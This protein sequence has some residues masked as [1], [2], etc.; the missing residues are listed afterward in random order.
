MDLGIAS[1]GNLKEKMHYQYKN[2][3]L[4][5]SIRVQLRYDKATNY[6]HT[7]VGYVVDTLSDHSL[8]FEGTWSNGRGGMGQTW[9]K[10]SFFIPNTPIQV[11][12][13]T[14]LLTE[15]NGSMKGS[16]NQTE[17]YQVSSSSTYYG[18]IKVAEDNVC[19]P[20][21]KNRDAKLELEG[22]IEVSYGIRADVGIPF[23]FD[24]F[25]EGSLG[26]R[27]KGSF[28]MLGGNDEMGSIHDCERCLDGDIELFIKE[29]V[30][31]D[32]R[33][34]STIT[35]HDLVYRWNIA[36]KALK[37]GDFYASYREE[38]DGGVE[39]GFG[40]CPHLRY[41]V[42]VYVK[43]PDGKAAANA[44][45]SAIYPDQRMDAATAN[46]EGVAELYLP[47]GDNILKGKTTG[48]SGSIHVAVDGKPTETVLPLE[49][50]KTILF[51]I[52]EAFYSHADDLIEGLKER[53]PEA[54][55]VYYA[56]LLNPID[57]NEE[58]IVEYGLSKGDIFVD[59]SKARFVSSASFY[60]DDCSGCKEDSGAIH[61]YP[62][63]IEMRFR[64]YRIVNDY[65]GLRANDYAVADVLYD[66]RGLGWPYAREPRINLTTNPE[67]SSIEKHAYLS[68]SETKYNDDFEIEGYSFDFL[69]YRTNSIFEEYA[70]VYDAIIDTDTIR[71]RIIDYGLGQIDFILELMFEEKDAEGY[72]PVLPYEIDLINGDIEGF[73][74]VTT[75]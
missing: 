63:R 35:G 17:S 71:S 25:A 56:D 74:N 11:G 21:G 66:P 65:D 22:N 12:V 33:I 45:V 61:A 5:R 53:Y 14:F 10:I 37:I 70:S 23:V 75:E 8:A 48:L 13:E 39:C 36:E 27:L 38:A 30:G 20:I 40:P 64:I 32:A 72:I 50:I 62:Y 7:N 46:E 68:F 60:R 44:H 4:M 51:M 34:V 69:R 67:F 2:Q 6:I 28:A 16:I 54:Q 43:K 29:D 41:K 59:V 31:V 24:V 19:E 73:E 49:E 58:R 9:P 57:Q 15:L 52:N 3:V 47:D 55:F 18:L 26:A 1:K 42:T